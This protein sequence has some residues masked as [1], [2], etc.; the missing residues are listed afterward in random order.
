MAGANSEGTSCA[1]GSNCSSY[2]QKLAFD[3][4]ERLSGLYPDC[5]RCASIRTQ[6]LMRSR[7]AVHTQVRSGT[8]QI[9]KGRNL[10][11]TLYRRTLRLVTFRPL[12]ELMAV[13]GA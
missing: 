9:H 10:R 3:L 8:C 2:W 5:A 12:R 4:A 7:R 1:V 13:A 11:N 6:P